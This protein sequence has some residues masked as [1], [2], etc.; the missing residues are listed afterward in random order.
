M[1]NG[2]EKLGGDSEKE[3]LCSRRTKA[4]KKMMYSLS[5]SNN[6]VKE[7]EEKNL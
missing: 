3:T 5:E 1:K 2:R 6:W 7:F 4:F